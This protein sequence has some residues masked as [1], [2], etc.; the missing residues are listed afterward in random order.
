MMFPS[1]IHN[2]RSAIRAKRHGFALP[3][4]IIAIAGLTLLLIGLL[5]VLSLE[6]KTA[7]SYSDAARADLAV[8]SGLAVA[9]ASLSEIAGR[10]DSIVFRIEDPLEPTVSADERPLGFREQYF[11]YGAVFENNAWR[12]IPLFSGESAIGLGADRIDTALLASALSAYVA[13][14]DTKTIVM[15]TEHDH[16]IPRAK[17]VEVPSSDP[18]GYIFRYSYWIEDL[19]GRIDGKNAGSMPQDLRLSMAELDMS[20]IFDPTASTGKVPPELTAKQKQLRTP[21]SVRTVLSADQAKRIEP[22]IHFHGM[23]SPTPA[24]KVIPQGFGYADA[25][26]PAPDLNEFVAAADVEGIAEHIEK[27]LPQL[28]NRKG[29]FPADE[30][31]IKTLAAS[32]IDYADEDNN[33]TIG[34]GYRGVDSYPF[35][36]EL[37]DRYEWTGGDTNSVEV[38][39]ESYVELWN[40]SDKATTGVIFFIN[41]NR[42]KIK[43]PPNDYEFTDSPRFIKPGIS[44]RPNGFLVIFLGSTKYKFPIN[45]TFPPTQLSFPNTE[46]S[47]FKLWWNGRLVD[48][49]RGGLMRQNSFMKFGNSERDWKGNASMALDYRID[50]DGDPRASYYIAAPVFYNNY[51]DNSNWGG[52]S[53]KRAISNNAYNEVRLQEWED[54]GTNS[55][56]GTNPRTDATRPTQVAFPANQPGLAPA[57][58]SNSGRYDSLAELGNIFDPAQYQRVD[59]DPDDSSPN[60]RPSPNPA[61]GG[62]FTLAIGRPEFGAFDTEGIRSA[63]LLDL[64]SIQPEISA[65]GASARPVNIN[66]AP[67][68]VLRTLV[69]GATLDADPATA[70]VV[71]PRDTN[72]GDIFANYVIAQRSHSPLRG[73]SDMNALRLDPA[74]KNATTFFGSRDAYKNGTAPP[75]TWDDAGREELFRKTLNLVS[76]TSKTFRIVVSGEALNKQGERI[77]RAAR[78]FHYSVE[79]VRDPAT[80]EIVAGAGG[81]PSL[82]IRKLYEKSL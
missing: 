50:Q 82:N 70:G 13:N 1:S 64:F 60:L 34:T 56:P 52:R 42:H 38:T 25:G 41:E 69:A 72:E 7:R 16:D 76:F 43:V 30:D 11:T 55:T 15:L 10:D 24:P 36:N 44:I 81:I 19:S 59:G 22:Y 65:S 80:G 21:A 62:G 48:R 27:N 74:D 37:F 57:S 73:P 61:A 20:T 49:A 4:T 33:A 75:D 45:P 26:T 6:R 3:M 28:K 18:D 54:R 39:V 14:E 77:G 53:L 58:I 2:P 32:M 17:W 78:E 23:A 8:E 47:N 63:Q 67:R 79:P 66:T 31:Y 68:E 29:G 71:P 9:L 40:P 46:S 35:V 51:R 12:G 5:T